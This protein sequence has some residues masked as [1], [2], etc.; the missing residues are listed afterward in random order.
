MY[1][2]PPA[3][4]LPV[5][6]P[7]PAPTPS[8]FGAAAEPRFEVVAGD[9]DLTELAALTLVLY[10]FTQSRPESADATRSVAE[11]WRRRPGEYRTAG[12]WRDTG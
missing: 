2:D 4:P 9:P 5:G 3:L 6:L 7:A 1:T 10:A 8:P 11:W 12:S